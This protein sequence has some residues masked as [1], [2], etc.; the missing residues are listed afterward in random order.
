MLIYFGTALQRRGGVDAACG[1]AWRLAA[2][3]VGRRVNLRVTKTPATVGETV[4]YFEKTLHL[5][6]VVALVNS[7]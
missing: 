2:T 3:M 4:Y 5:V 1:L 7:R 6:V